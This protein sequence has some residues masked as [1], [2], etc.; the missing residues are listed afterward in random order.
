MQLDLMDPTWHAHWNNGSHNRVCHC[1]GCLS[2]I[3]A[4]AIKQGDPRH[5][6]HEMQNQKHKRRSSKKHL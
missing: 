1:F 4:Q 5:W 3:A 2:E 6:D